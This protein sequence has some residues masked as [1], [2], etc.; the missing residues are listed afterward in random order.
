[1]V[2]SLLTLLC[3]HGNLTLKLVSSRVSAPSPPPR[4]INSARSPLFGQPPVELWG[5]DQSHPKNRSPKELPPPYK[6]TLV[7]YYQKKMYWSAFDITWYRTLY[8]LKNEIL[9]FMLPNTWFQILY[10]SFSC[11]SLIWSLNV[12]LLLIFMLISMFFRFLTFFS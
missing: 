5:T 10:C 8:T 2:L 12:M 1:M 9:Q 3:N 11:L 4:N 7:S 6:I